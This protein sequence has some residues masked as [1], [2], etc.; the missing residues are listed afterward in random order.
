MNMLI[1]G[2]VATGKTFLANALRQHYEGQ[3]QHCDILEDDGSHNDL[4][5]HFLAGPKATAKFLKN[6]SHNATKHFILTTQMFPG[7]ILRPSDSTAQPLFDYV[8]CT[9]RLSASQLLH[10][11]R[12]YE[13]V[14]T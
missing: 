14:E 10:V 5:A 8:Y 9:E 1:Y 4:G 6:T 7:E 2:K 3:G 13:M 11:V 12:K